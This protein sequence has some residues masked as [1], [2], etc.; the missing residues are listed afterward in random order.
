MHAQGPSARFARAPVH[1]PVHPQPRHLSPHFYLSDNRHTSS[2]AHRPPLK[3]SEGGRPADDGDDI[4]ENRAAATTA[5][6]PRSSGEVSGG[7]M[8][9]VAPWSRWVCWAARS[10]A[11]CVR[12]LAS[13]QRCKGGEF[14]STAPR[15][16]GGGTTSTRQPTGEPDVA[17]VGAVRGEFICPVCVVSSSVICVSGWAFLRAAPADAPAVCHAPLALVAQHSA[18]LA[19]CRQHARVAKA[20]MAVAGGGGSAGGGRPGSA[21]R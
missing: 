16:I 11:R 17:R 6:R 2:T 10:T 13:A 5:A 12:V 15:R 18:I 9:A 19:P 14:L 21:P 8:V 3:R 1:P 7:P 20:G 4:S